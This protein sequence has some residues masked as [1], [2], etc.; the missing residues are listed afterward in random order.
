MYFILYRVYI[1]DSI[2][3]IFIYIYRKAC[4]QLQWYS[5]VIMNNI[6]E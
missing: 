5:A 6:K 2:L 1:M 3:I 4:M